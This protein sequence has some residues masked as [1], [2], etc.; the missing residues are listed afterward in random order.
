MGQV[1]A[2]DLPARSAGSTLGVDQGGSWGEGAL[3]CHHSPSTSPHLSWVGDIGGP[4]VSPQASDSQFPDLTSCPERSPGQTTEMAKVAP[5]PS[6]EPS[7]PNKCT[8][9]VLPRAE[10]A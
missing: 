5:L 1:A 9:A 8:D 3:S 10:S 2:T 4:Y 6:P 7:A